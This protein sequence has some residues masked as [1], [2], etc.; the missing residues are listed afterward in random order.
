MPNALTVGLCDCGKESYPSRRAATSSAKVIARNDRN[1]GR[2]D[3]ELRAYEC[4]L[5]PGT[6]HLTHE[7]QTKASVVREVRAS[8]QAV[9]R[10]PSSV[11]FGPKVEPA[12][13]TPIRAA[14]PKRKPSHAP[15]HT[16]CS[17]PACRRP[18]LSDISP[19]NRACPACGSAIELG[20]DAHARSFIRELAA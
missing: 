18:W 15:E 6:F 14:A 7:R 1:R 2:Q 13:V 9:V 12:K 3:R 11:V 17:N 10:E 16:C 4:A 19:L 20:R 8:T 5:S